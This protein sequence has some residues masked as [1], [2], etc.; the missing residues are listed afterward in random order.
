MQA[1]PGVPAIQ[2][3][4]NP[5]AWMLEITTPGMEHQLA[6]DFAQVYK[7]SDLARSVA[8]SS[9]SFICCI[10]LS[11]FALAIKCSSLVLLISFWCDRRVHNLVLFLGFLQDRTQLVLYYM[12]VGQIC[13]QL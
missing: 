11:N 6:V 4:L 7:E 10:F 1:V 5:A 9:S 8:T 13:C 12:S 2:G 3:E